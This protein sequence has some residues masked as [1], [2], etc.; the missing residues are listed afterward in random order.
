MT[1]AELIEA[2]KG[3]DPGREVVMSSDG[4][5]N[6][7]S[8]LDGFSTCGYLADTTWSGETGIEE[9]TPELRAQGYSEDDMLEGAVPAV[10]LWP[11]N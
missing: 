10:C 3:L 1:V 9:L 7:H 2:L 11:T 6:N 8:P 5:G 4:E